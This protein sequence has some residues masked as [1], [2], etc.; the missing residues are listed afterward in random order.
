MWDT[1]LGDGDI[2]SKTNQIVQR[3]LE[4]NCLAQCSAP[5]NMLAMFFMFVLFYC[6]M[7]LLFLFLLAIIFYIHNSHMGKLKFGDPR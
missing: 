4:E 6:Y 5:N 7:C 2:M 3:G 1:V